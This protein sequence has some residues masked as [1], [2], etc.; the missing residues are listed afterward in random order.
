MK[1]RG[2]RLSEHDEQAL[3]VEWARLNVGRYPP[4]AWLYAIPNGG[5]RHIRQAAM[6]KAEGVLAGVSDLCLPYPH[7]GYHGLYIE[8]KRTD[9]H[10]S[11]VSQ[12]QRAFIDWA[13]ANGY[14]AVV[15]FGADAI[16]AAL[17][18][19]LK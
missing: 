17:V 14:R 19:Y 8:S 16:I 15:C 6:L 2:L 9:G 12:E 13:N 18:E 11:D 5:H 3:A 10:P 7:S 4:L 1:A